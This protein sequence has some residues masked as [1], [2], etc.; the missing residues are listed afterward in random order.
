[1]LLLTAA[2]AARLPALYATERLALPDKAVQVKFFTPWTNWTW[3]LIEYDP[4]E[5]LCW[6]WVIGL[7]QEAGYFSLGELEAIR[8]PAGLRIERD[9]HFRP[10][11]L[12]DVP[13][14]VLR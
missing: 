10:C 1:M 4:A 12:G 9:A 14:V 6:G 3:L 5:R 8:G 13:G 2:D 7:E 11:R